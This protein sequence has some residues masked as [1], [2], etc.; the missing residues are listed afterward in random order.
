VEARSRPADVN[1]RDMRSR[2][3]RRRYSR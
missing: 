2:A 3:I 1:Q